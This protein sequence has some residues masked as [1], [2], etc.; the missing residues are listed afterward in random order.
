M[1]RLND[2]RAALEA[3]P[4]APNAR[5]E[6]VL[7]VEDAVLPQ[8]ARS[9]RLTAREGKLRVRPETGRSRRRLPRVEVPADMLGPLVAGTVSP[10]R[11][12]EVGLIG[13]AHGGAEAIERWFR[14]QPAFLYRLNAF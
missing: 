14:A 9:Y 6:C 2:V 10:M 1:L 12:D 7:Q 3:L 4:V 5:G 11:A 13:S 8:N